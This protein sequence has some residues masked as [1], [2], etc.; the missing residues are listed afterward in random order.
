M[1]LQ[2]KCWFHGLPTEKLKYILHQAYGDQACMVIEKFKRSKSCKN[3]VQSNLP[4]SYSIFWAKSLKPTLSSLILLG[5]LSNNPNKLFLLSTYQPF[6]A[7]V[8]LHAN[9]GL[10]LNPFGWDRQAACLIYSN[11]S[12]SYKCLIIFPYEYGI[13]FFSLI[14]F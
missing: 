8:G 7:F 12:A 1:D 2:I 5:I 6:P 14:E 10:V 9:L 11:F 3:V 13:I 4:S